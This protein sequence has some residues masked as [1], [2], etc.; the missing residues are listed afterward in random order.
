MANAFATRTAMQREHVE[1]PEHGEN[2]AD[3][4]RLTPCLAI[5]GA[6]RLEKSGIS[7]LFIDFFCISNPCP[8]LS[9]PRTPLSRPH[10][11]T[12]TAYGCSRAPRHHAPSTERAGAR[13]ARPIART[14][15]ER[16]EAPQQRTGAHPHMRASEGWG[17]PRTTLGCP[18]S[19]AHSPG[20]VPSQRRPLGLDS[21]AIC[22]R[23]EPPPPLL[24]TLLIC[25]CRRC[26]RRCC[27]CCRRRCCCCCCC[28]ATVLL[29]LLLL[30]LQRRRRQCKHRP[31][32]RP[33]RSHSRVSGH[34]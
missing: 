16:T 18:S 24:P 30:L 6:Q 12:S 15:R 34:A 31:R 33:R 25:C 9:T 13:A 8:G 10:R 19:K 5:S 23:R 7:N 26:R 27:H 2:G 22:H 14:E 17:G 11:D 21:G 20:T 28:A 4:Q 32:A 29:L 1:Q 3:E